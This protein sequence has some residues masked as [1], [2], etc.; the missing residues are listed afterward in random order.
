MVSGVGQG[1]MVVGGGGGDGRPAVMG[2]LLA[3]TGVSL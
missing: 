1:D 2:P 3:L